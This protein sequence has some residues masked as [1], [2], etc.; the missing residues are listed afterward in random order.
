MAEAFQS[1]DG[2]EIA[3]SIMGDGPTVMLLHG[4]FSNAD[5]NWVRYGTARRLVEAGYRLILPDFRGHGAS[6]CPDAA[7]A[8]PADVLALDTEALIAHLNLGTDFTL[9]GYSLGA[10]TAVRV[11]TRGTN[12]KAAIASGMGLQGITGGAARGAWFIRMIEGAGSWQRG[13]HEYVAEAFMKANVKNPAAIIH[14]LRS[15]QS[16]TAETLASLT[17]PV[18]VPCGVDD[19]DNGSAPDLAHALGD[20]R[21]VEIPVTHMSAVTRPELATAMVDFLKGSDRV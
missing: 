2:T 18:C 6:A 20:G 16:T 13:S 10:R 19:E 11:L 21:Y 3:Y 4:L 15:Q 14:L 17:L 5:T 1:F 7:D 8:W 12:P 9:G